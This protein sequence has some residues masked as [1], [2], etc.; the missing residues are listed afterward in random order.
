MVGGSVVGRRVSMRRR[1]AAPDVA[2][3]Q[4][5]SEVNPRPADFQAVLAAWW[6]A[7]NRPGSGGR[8]MSAGVGKIDASIVVAHDKADASTLTAPRDTS[9][10]RQAVRR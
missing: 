6:R 3:R 4:A 8:D 2:A 7:M 9:A 5:D 1:I 10:L